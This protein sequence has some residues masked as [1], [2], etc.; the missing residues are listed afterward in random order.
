[1]FNLGVT[2]N[3]SLNINFRSRRI[4]WFFQLKGT[5]SKKE[6]ENGITEPQWRHQRETTGTGITAEYPVLEWSTDAVHSVS[7]G[8]SRTRNLAEASCDECPEN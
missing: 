6:T 5:F 2:I 4:E 1:M 8:H 7:V 3:T